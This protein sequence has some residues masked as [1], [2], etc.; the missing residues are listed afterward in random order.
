MGSFRDRYRLLVLVDTY[1]SDDWHDPKL[2]LLDGPGPTHSPKA[3]TCSIFLVYTSP[4]LC[5]V[6]ILCPSLCKVTRLS[7]M[8]GSTLAMKDFLHSSCCL[9][10]RGRSLDQLNPREP[11]HLGGLS[12]MVHSITLFVET[13]SSNSGDSRAAQIEPSFF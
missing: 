8:M 13:R 10:Y 2:V 3:I 7:R 1:F 9:L 11:R 6:A 4:Q 12:F 5:P